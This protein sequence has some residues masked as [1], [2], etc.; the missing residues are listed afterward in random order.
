MSF[1]ACEHLSKCLLCLT[2]IS[3]PFHSPKSI[4]VWM[5]NY[6][7]ILLVGGR[8]QFY[9]FPLPLEAIKSL[10]RDRKTFSSNIPFT[11]ANIYWVPNKCHILWKTLKIKCLLLYFHFIWIQVV[12]ERLYELTLW[13]KSLNST[14]TGYLFI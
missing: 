4:L 8:P 11:L 10:P 9:K 14:G 1:F 6:I 13:L 3:I 7:V 5:K 12:G 2:I